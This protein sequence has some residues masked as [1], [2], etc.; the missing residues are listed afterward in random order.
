MSLTKTVVATCG[1]ISDQKE[2]SHCVSWCYIHLLRAVYLKKNGHCPRAGTAKLSNPQTK[3]HN[4]VTL[5][6]VYFKVSLN[7]FE[8]KWMGFS[9][10]ILESNKIFNYF[11]FKSNS[12]LSDQFSPWYLNLCIW[13]YVNGNI[14]QLHKRNLKQKLNMLIKYLGLISYSITGNYSKYIQNYLTWEQS[15]FRPF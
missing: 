8:L 10:K 14:F 6:F 11:E 2:H 13:S 5:F 12:K 4:N 1:L 3:Q 9:R 7:L 15:Y